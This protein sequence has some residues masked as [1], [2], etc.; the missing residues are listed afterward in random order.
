MKYYSFERATSEILT[1]LTHVVKFPEMWQLAQHN[2]SIDRH[3]IIRNLR[4]HSVSDYYSKP[5]PIIA[6]TIF[7]VSF[8]G[9]FL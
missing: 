4:S 1:A 9:I 6:R 2:Y 8:N 5:F 7:P 3:A